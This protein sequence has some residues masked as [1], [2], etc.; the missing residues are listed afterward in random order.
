[1]TAESESPM[2][3][4]GTTR[5]LLVE[6]DEMLREMLATRL[7]RAGFEILQA[8][9][10]EEALVLLDKSPPDVVLC[11]AL[12]PGMTGIDLLGRIREHHDLAQM[13]VIIS[14]SLHDGALMVQ[15]MSKG[16]NDFLSKPID[17]SAAIA[18]IRAQA[19]LKL[20]AE[21]NHRLTRHLAEAN[22]RLE[23]SNLHL[24]RMNIELEADA[25]G[26][27]ARG[28]TPRGRL[29]CISKLG[30]ET[31]S[32]IDQ[33]IVLQRVVSAGAELLGSNRS[34]FLRLEMGMLRPVAWFP[35]Q[36][37]AGLAIDATNA[38]SLVAQTASASG[39]IIGSAMGQEPSA[40]GGNIAACPIFNNAGN[41]EGVL[42]FSR[43]AGLAFDA[44]DKEVLRALGT[45]CSANLQRTS[46]TRAHIMCMVRMAT[47][48]DPSE[49][50][51]HARRVA[52]IAVAV[53]DA[54]AAARAI[55]EAD[56]LA[57]RDML[58]AG[59]LMHDIGKV[60]IADEILKKPGR[61]T[62]IEFDSM[63]RHTTIGSDLVAGMGGPF[64]RVARDIALCHHERWDGAG[65]PGRVLPDGTNRGRSDQDIPLFAR[66][67]ALADVY[68]ALSCVRR[69]KE[70]WPELEVL[71]LLRAESG[72]HFDPEVVDAAL[73][74]PG[75]LR[76]VLDS[77]PES[78][79]AG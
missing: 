55:P 3:R 62:Q 23:E 56:R 26:E 65:Y 28:E 18:R 6:V 22:R 48:R 36:D 17:F 69:Y 41:P 45:L 61:L 43:S 59:A 75:L 39:P 11:D 66:F 35:E 70:A 40:L 32:W 72:G 44:A 74:N 25:E 63:K 2:D 52:G 47:L 9:S 15:A 50:T 1:M 71:A 58:H 79:A 37:D 14:T 27:R 51:A 77:F 73:S 64:E 42:A 24:I 38:D 78:N 19:R 30:D 68:D 31:A 54:W 53:Y 5:V 60:A 33:D 21:E 4:M 67:V 10:G 46:L 76:Q 34:C 49:T 57:Q 29:R 20:M 7:E 8:A 13:P 16:A 12:L